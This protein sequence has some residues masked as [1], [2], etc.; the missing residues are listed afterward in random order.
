MN[1]IVQES[2]SQVQDT[3][4]LRRYVAEQIVVE[5]VVSQE[6]KRLHL[7]NDA[8]TKRHWLNRANWLNRKVW[9]NKLAS[10]NA[11]LHTKIKC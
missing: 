7:E 10:N 1:A 4:D 3:P 6:A 2:K 11:G 8:N 5:T 9:T